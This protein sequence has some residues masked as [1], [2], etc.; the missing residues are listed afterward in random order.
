VSARREAAM[1][2]EG[3]LCIY[4]SPRHKLITDSGRVRGDAA[5]VESPVLLLA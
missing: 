5:H 1:R 2:R 3:T 4:F